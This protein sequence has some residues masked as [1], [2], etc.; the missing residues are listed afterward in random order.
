MAKKE[1]MDLA[2]KDAQKV[3]LKQF[4]SG[5]HYFSYDKT[6]SVKEFGRAKVLKAKFKKKR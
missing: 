1:I 5:N 2:V 4:E 6:S 3:D